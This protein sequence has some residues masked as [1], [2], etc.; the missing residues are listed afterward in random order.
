MSMMRC[1]WCNRSVDTDQD[2]EMLMELDGDLLCDTCR[3]R[4][5]R[6]Q[7]PEEAEPCP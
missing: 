6:N 2:T 4:W 3:D 1:D 5:A 7:A